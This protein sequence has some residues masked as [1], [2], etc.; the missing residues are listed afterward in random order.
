MAGKGPRNAALLTPGVSRA[1]DLSRWKHRGA[2]A[3]QLAPL[4]RFRFAKE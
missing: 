4:G 1:A 2:G 3:Y